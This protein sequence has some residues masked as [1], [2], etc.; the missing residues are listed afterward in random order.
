MSASCGSF[1]IPSAAKVLRVLLLRDFGWSVLEKRG[2]TFVGLASGVRGGPGPRVTADLSTALGGDHLLESLEAR[3]RFA[4][5]LVN[6]REK[7]LA[8]LAAE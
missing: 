3:R 6:V 4:H 7:V 2:A 1:L 5:P 8:L